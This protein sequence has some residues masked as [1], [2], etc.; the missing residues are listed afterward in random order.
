MDTSLDL[1]DHFKLEVEQLP[2]YTQHTH[3][4][5]DRSHGLRRVKIVKRWRKK[6]DIGEGTF[7]VVWLEVEE[8]GSERAVKAIS[9]RLCSY[10]KIDYKKE[11]AAMAILSKVMPPTQLRLALAG[12][13]RNSRSSRSS[14]TKS[15]LWHSMDG[16]KAQ[17]T[18][19]SPWN[20][21]SMAICKNT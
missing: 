16:S 10:N 14:S 13:L 1:V 8:D 9:R 20:T 3:Y 11:L 19:S 17:I 15:F 5:S 7:G 2:D 4:K 6:H 12:A 18:S 21:S